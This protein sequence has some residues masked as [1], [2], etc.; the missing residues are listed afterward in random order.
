MDNSNRGR[1]QW[2]TE[3]PFIYLDPTTISESFT[4][5][6]SFQLIFFWIMRSV[7]INLKYELVI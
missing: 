6:F 5:V 7:T 1:G 2:R 4:K 3:I